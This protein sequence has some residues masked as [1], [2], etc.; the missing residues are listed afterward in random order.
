MNS[1]NIAGLTVNF[2]PFG[3]T[4]DRAKPYLCNYTDSP[5]FTISV[6][7]EMLES[8]I[9]K[10][11][12]Y[13]RSMAYY[14]VSGFLFYR[15]LLKYDGFMLHSSA[16]GYDGYA[17]LFSGQSGIGKSTHTR[18]WHEVLGD[19]VYVINDDKPAVK[20]EN[21]VVMAYGTPWSGKHDISKNVGHAVKGIAFIN[22]SETNKISVMDKKLSAVHIVNQLT[23]NFSSERWEKVLSLVDK[24]IDSVPV[25]RLECNMQKEAAMLSIETMSGGKNEN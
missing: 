7:E 1:Y 20:I 2:E 6:K 4:L 16:I 10:H 9:Q 12:E 17:Y 3:I 15:Y 19:K 5:D 22:R 21:G 24:V 18:L 14:F 8:Y 11:P 23:G 25:Y 13:D